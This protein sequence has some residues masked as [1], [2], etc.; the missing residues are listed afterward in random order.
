MQRRL[1]AFSALLAVVGLVACASP[2]PKLYTLSDVPPAAAASP[3]ARAGQTIVLREIGLARYLDRP[4]IVRSTD[5]FQVAVSQD[6]W[7]GEPLGRMIGRVLVADLA[8]RLPGTPVVA[9]SGAIG[10]RQGDTAVE[11]NIVGFAADRAGSVRLSA[12]IAV[13]P[14]DRPAERRVRARDIVVAM[15]GKDAKAQVAAMS[16]ALGQLADAI[17]DTLRQ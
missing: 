15:D 7:W 5:D 16:V 11:V 1:P 13:V 12:Q 17:V 10:A 14:R 9:E 2:D 3:L 8:A 4:Q 6:D